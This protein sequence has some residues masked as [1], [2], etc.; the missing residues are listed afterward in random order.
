MKRLKRGDTVTRVVEAI[1]V[2]HAQWSN[3]DATARRAARRRRDGQ[4]GGSGW[5]WGDGCGTE[6]EIRAGRPAPE[7]PTGRASKARFRTSPL[8]GAHGGR[9][10]V[11]DSTTVFRL[12]DAAR[13][14]PHRPAS[15]S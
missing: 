12:M 10:R 3:S 13:S 1:E 11:N 7:A 2:L 14:K 9:A 6:R 5:G 4:G 15:D 8:G